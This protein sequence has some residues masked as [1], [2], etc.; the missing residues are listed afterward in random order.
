MYWIEV[1]L[2]NGKK[3][4]Y[5]SERMN[6]TYAFRGKYE[7]MRKLRRCPTVV[8]MHAGKGDQTTGHWTYEN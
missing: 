4:R 3:I 1:T 8:E 5:E 6:D 7:L 2:D